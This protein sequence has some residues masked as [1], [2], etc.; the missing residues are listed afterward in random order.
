MVVDGQ[1]ISIL[2]DNY[3]RDDLITEK[4]ATASTGQA[5]STSAEQNRCYLFRLQMLIIDGGLLILRNIFDKKLQNSSLSL[6]VFLQQ[7]RL[8]LTNL[9]SK[10]KITQVQYDLLYPSGGSGSLTTDLDVTLIM[11]LLR[12]FK[13]FGLNKNFQWNSY[14][15][16]GD[17]S[18]EA[19]MFR[20]TMYRNELSHI[21]STR[22]ITPNVFTTKWTEIEQV[23]MVLYITIISH[24]FSFV[25]LRLNSKA[26]PIPHLQKTIDDFKVSPLD[27]E[28]E[29]R[30]QKAIDSWQMLEKGVEA[31]LKLIKEDTKDIKHSVESQAERI[32]ELNKK[33]SEHEK[34]IQELKLK[35]E[36]R[37]DVTAE[38]QSMR[39]SQYEEWTK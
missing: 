7:K 38:T 39:L 30:V 21:S 19:D 10:G 24:S 29:R 1:Y 11:F 20:L 33:T 18:I 25:L 31:E 32:D 27:Q 5:S 23:R 14:P 9:R 34:Q 16:Q 2:S 13:S 3:T 17:T 36:P 26:T 4:M 35:E 37:K 15:A 8:K 28:A 22:G 6:S 12:N